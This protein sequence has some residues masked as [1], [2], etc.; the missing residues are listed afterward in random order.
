MA[1]RLSSPARTD[2]DDIWQ[3]V[4]IESGSEAAADRA[5]DLITDRFLLLSHWPRLGRA[6]NDLRRGLRS[7]PDGDYVIFYRVTRAGLIIQRV[8]HGRRDIA[9]ILGS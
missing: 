2:L 9:K 1:H 8:L 4:V 5:V 3:H 7:F 6:R